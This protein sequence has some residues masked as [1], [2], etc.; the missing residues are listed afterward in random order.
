MSPIGLARPDSPS[1]TV[2]SV[3]IPDSITTVGTEVLPITDKG[4]RLEFKK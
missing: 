2:A 1:G 3:R 4:K